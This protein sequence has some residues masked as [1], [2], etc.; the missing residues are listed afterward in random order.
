MTLSLFEVHWLG[1]RSKGRNQ[2]MSQQKMKL[3]QNLLNVKNSSHTLKRVCTT[4][5]IFNN[6]KT[7]L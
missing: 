7:N 3:D 5:P 6:L 2:W 4:L 1:G